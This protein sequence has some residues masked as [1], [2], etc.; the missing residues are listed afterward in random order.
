MRIKKFLE[1]LT[2]SVK[3][4]YRPALLPR[5]AIYPNK[6][7]IGQGDKLLPNETFEDRVRKAV[8][9]YVFK[10]LQETLAVFAYL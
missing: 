6:G 4:S 7:S 3:E 2:Y 9:R 5:I 8:W 10:E 1:N